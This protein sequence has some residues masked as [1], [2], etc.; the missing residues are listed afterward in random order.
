M[1]VS[2]DQTL[3]RGDCICELICRQVFVLDEGGIAY[4]TENGVPLEGPERWAKVPDG[5]ESLVL[6]AAR[7]CP[8]QAIFLRGAEAE[9]DEEAS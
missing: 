7:E 2:L 8:A 9:M 4:V 3:C 6:D 5:L 1:E